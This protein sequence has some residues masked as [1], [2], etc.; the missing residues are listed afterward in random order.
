MA[1]F[2]TKFINHE[3]QHPNSRRQDPEK[4]K[5][6]NFNNGNSALEHSLVVGPYFFSA[7]RKWRCHR[8]ENGGPGASRLILMNDLTFSVTLGAVHLSQH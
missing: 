3:S 4:L 6:S 5:T 8:S 1:E 2:L 7:Y